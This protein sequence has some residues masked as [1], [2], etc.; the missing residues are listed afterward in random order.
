ME[1]PTHLLIP[2]SDPSRK[3]RH[4]GPFCWHCVHG[5]PVKWAE[6]NNW[7]VSIVQEVIIKIGCFV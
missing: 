5:I 7:E 4:D 2:G 6:N 3:F 1:P